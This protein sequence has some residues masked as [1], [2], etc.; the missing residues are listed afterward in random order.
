MSV[1]NGGMRTETDSWSKNGL[2]A[3]G[4]VFHVP[5]ATRRN[6]QDFSAVNTTELLI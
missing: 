5:V 3:D 1:A 6:V 2:L 4:T